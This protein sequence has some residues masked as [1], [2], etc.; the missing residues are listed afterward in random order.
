MSGIL[1]S[2]LIITPFVLGGICFFLRRTK[3]QNALVILNSVIL[4]IASVMLAVSGGEFTITS[5]AVPFD[6]TSV[7]AAF[8]IL[9]L[10]IITYFGFKHKHWTVVTLSVIQAVMLVYLELVVF[11]TI[12]NEDRFLPFIYVDYL[13]VIMLLIV[14]VVGSLICTFAMPY[15]KHH[16]HQF[17]LP[18]IRKSSF[19]MVMLM[20]L[21]AMN[22]LVVSNNLLFL[23]AFFEFTTL[24]SFLLINYDKSFIATKN[25]LR[26]LWMNSFGGV[27]LLTAVVLFYVKLETLDIR[28]LIDLSIGNDVLILPLT[29]LLLAS[30][31]KSAQ[32]PFQSWLVGAM[33]APTPVS[34]LLHS[35]T[36]VKVG[37]YMAIRFAPAYAD[38]FLASAVA[39]FGGFVFLSAAISAL[40]QTNG[41]KILAYST[42]S[43]LGLI[44]ACAG[45]GTPEAITAGIFLIIFHAVSKALLFLGTGAVEQKIKSRD[46]EQMQGLYQIMPVVTVFMLIGIVSVILPPFGMLVGKWMILEAAASINLPVIV[47]LALG[48]SVTF[49]YWTRWTGLLLNNYNKTDLKVGHLH[50]WTIFPLAALVTLI[51][52]LALFSPFIFTSAIVPIIGS[53][54]LSPYDVTNAGLLSYQGSFWVLPISVLAITAVILGLNYARGFKGKYIA[55]AKTSPFMCGINAEKEDEFIGPFDKKDTYKVFNYYF[56]GFGGGSDSDKVQKVFNFTALII[57]CFMLGGAM[58]YYYGFAGIW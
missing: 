7:I 56:V 43:N 1:L 16:N 6:V 44:F 57:L 45:V 28:Q 46:I 5:D 21:G 35:S 53:F 18:H 36:M 48:S 8:D 50:F 30:F 12:G 27:A 33:V 25:A 32:P 39:V 34:A 13:S 47:L 4:I 38:S 49:V 29:L 31:I 9:I 52:L 10:G 51:V 37:V 42:I 41:K 40:S 3:Y 17:T 23:Y 15:M 24:C 22:A 58:Q 26:A 54:G 2:L 14:S 55:K 19:F 11:K 20:F